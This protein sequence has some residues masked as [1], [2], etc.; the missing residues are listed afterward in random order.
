MTTT[1]SP[2]P[3]SPPVVA[4]MYASVL[5]INHRYGTNVSVHTS[6]ATA[7]AAAAKFARSW[8]GDAVHSSG[9][10]DMPEVPTRPPADDD[11]TVSIYFDA[12]MHEETAVIYSMPAES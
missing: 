6:H 12:M 10:H 3:I 4:G 2:P 9:Q 8:W 7:L 5:I 11:E 1:D